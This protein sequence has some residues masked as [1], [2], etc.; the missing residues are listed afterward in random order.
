M[1]NAS[2]A[3]IWIMIFA[4]L[5]K[6][7]GRADE[8]KLTPAQTALSN[9]TI[10]GYVDVAIDYSTVQSNT[11][12]L[13]DNAER[14]HWSAI[15]GQVLLISSTNHT[16]ES[17]ACQSTLVIYNIPNRGRISLVEQFTTADDGTFVLQLPPGT[18]VV[19]PCLPT[20]NVTLSSKPVILKVVA[21]RIT[22][23]GINIFEGRNR[24]IGNSSSSSVSLE[25]NRLRE[26]AGFGSQPPLPPAPLIP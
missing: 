21:R 25:A 22:P 26:G 19:A 10:S 24:R 6:T 14:L 1:K 23:V 12:T 8:Y 18:Y 2:R 15:A 16:R 13:L 9:T 17:F 7:T 11:L 3:I 20:Q 4:G 5:L